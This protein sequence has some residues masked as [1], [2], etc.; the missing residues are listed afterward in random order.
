ML[1]NS[2]TFPLIIYTHFSF[3]GYHLVHKIKTSPFITKLLEFFIV[4]KKYYIFSQIF[5]ISFYKIIFYTWR[6]YIIVRK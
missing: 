2:T 3:V 5:Q 6:I 4:L 1:H